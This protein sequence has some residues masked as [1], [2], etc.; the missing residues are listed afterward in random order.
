MGRS[1]LGVQALTLPLMGEATIRMLGGQI[2]ASIYLA[3]G[4]EPI[5]R[6]FLGQ[7]SIYEFNLHRL[8]MNNNFYIKHK[9]KFKCIKDNIKLSLINVQTN[10]SK[11]LQVPYTIMH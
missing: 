2:D 7:E 5:S 9:I 4:S 8:Y 11:L 3:L 1:N 10:N 6:L